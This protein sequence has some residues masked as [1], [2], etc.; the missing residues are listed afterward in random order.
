MLHLCEHLPEKASPGLG[1]WGGEPGQRKLCSSLSD[2]AHGRMNSVP[3]KKSPI[4]PFLGS[5]G[6]LQLRVRVGEAVSKTRQQEGKFT[7]SHPTA[8]PAF[9]ISVLPSTKALGSLSCLS[10]FCLDPN[11][12]A[13]KKM[14][15]SPLSLSVI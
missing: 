15:F 10:F 11:C 3:F 4:L 5:V 9:H 1:A 8:S 14:H 2:S 13:F 12:Q 6:F 7:W